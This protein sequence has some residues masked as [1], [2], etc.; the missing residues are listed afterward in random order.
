MKLLLFLFLVLGVPSTFAS[1]FRIR[2]DYY[3]EYLDEYEYDPEYPAYPEYPEYPD[4]NVSSIL[5]HVQCK[6]KNG[7]LQCSVEDAQARK[8]IR[9]LDGDGDGAATLQEITDKIDQ[10]DREL[11]FSERA[12]S[13]LQARI[14]IHHEI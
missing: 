2:P 3:E 13:I 5:P 14:S 11:G 1:T 12:G 7:W 6:M 9:Y 10:L 4:H 8:F